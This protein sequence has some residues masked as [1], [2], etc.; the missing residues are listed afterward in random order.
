MQYDFW[1]SAKKH[2]ESF[3]PNAWELFCA[4]REKILYAEIP[5]SEFMQDELLGILWHESNGSCYIDS[6]EIDTI[7]S[8][9]DMTITQLCAT[10]LINK[11]NDECKRIS[12]RNGVMC[13]NAD[14]LS[15]RKYLLDYKQE[16]FVFEKPGSF[17][18]LKYL[19]EFL[20]NS[21]VMVDPHIL[22]DRKYV[23]NVIKHLLKNILPES[24]DLPFQISIFSGIGQINDDT[25]GE[26]FY[27]DIRAMIQTIR[28][29]LQF[30]LTVYQIPIQGDGW[31]RRLLITNTFF[32]D[33]PDGFD[34]FK[35]N[36]D[37]KQLVASKETCF[38]IYW[39][40]LS[41]TKIDFFYNYI[42]KT[43][44][45]SKKKTGYHHARWGACKNRLFDFVE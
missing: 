10:Y 16:S 43:S 45:E 31:H 42:K 36:R 39:P 14:M 23:D 19:R 34:V 38:N 18:N 15:N 20:C 12:S 11:N 9:K 6:G 25:L 1:K 29:Y 28:P 44:E 17:Y 24:I 3:G 21:L 13:V 33:A 22:K 27:N 8:N 35:Y 26:S 30:D 7:L 40:G 37:S 41:K 2:T 5:I 4:C 32:I